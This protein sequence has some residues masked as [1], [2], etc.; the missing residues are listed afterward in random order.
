MLSSNVV[1]YKQIHPTKNT[2]DVN[3][4]RLR[5]N[6]KIWWICDKGHEWLAIIDNRTTRKAQCPYCMNV[7]VCLLNCME[8]TYPNIALEWHPTKNGVLTPKDILPGTNVKY[9]W[10]CSINPGHEWETTPNVRCLKSC[11]C[12]HCNGKTTYGGNTIADKYPEIAK[13]WHPTKNGNIK[14]DAICP[15]AMTK[16]WWICPDKHEYIAICNNRT[17]ERNTGC[18]Y[19]AG[20]LVCLKNSLGY[21]YPEIAKEWHPTKNSKTP[22]DFT[23][24]S[25]KKVWWR[26]IK[27][28]T[29]EWFIDISNRT[30][31]KTGCPYC[32]VSH[33][34][35]AVELYCK[36]Q[37]IKFE[38]QKKY[39]KDGLGNLSYDF[40]LRDYNIL[41]ECDGQQHFKEFP[42]YFHKKTSFNYQRIRDVRKNIF[43]L[44]K[45]IALIRIA[46]TD[47]KFIE[48]LLTAFIARV[49]RGFNGI[50]FTNHSLYK[51]R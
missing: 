10:K 45:K 8:T 38:Q 50:V 23:S 20:K 24:H 15:K 19:C 14:P 3:K 18:P 44:Q 6:K 46:F 40:Y 30:S 39:K 51:R 11:G 37:N 49:K 13:E 22:A 7:K 43:A 17:S 12:P 42:D 1:L 16:I 4:L 27:N 28:P 35:S 25:G 26:C 9:W 41:V 34:E 5:S 47:E 36:R 29:H 32:N 2:I 33:M 21:C 31:H 48:S